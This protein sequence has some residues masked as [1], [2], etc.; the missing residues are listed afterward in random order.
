MYQGTNIVAGCN[1]GG[2]YV[3][4]DIGTTWTPPVSGLTNTHVTSLALSGSTLLAG[5]AGG[6]FLS[7]DGGSTWK[8][9]NTGLNFNMI[10]AAATVGADFLAAT[11][12]GV[13][14]STDGG[15]NWVESDNGMSIKNVSTFAVNGTNV[16]A[17]GSSGTVYLSTDSGV[18]WRNCSAGVQLGPVMSLLA[19]EWYLFA[20]V[21]DGGVWRRSMSE[22]L[23][24]DQNPALRPMETSLGQNFPNPFNP[25]TEIQYT[26]HDRQSTSIKVFDILGREVA[27]LLDEVKEPGRYSVTWNASGV[28][29]GVYYCRMTT[30]GSSKS[31]K[32]V[33][34]R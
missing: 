10:F 23:S 6:A 26:I 33:L 28:A 32:M 14:R 7:T 12:Y 8:V 16:F 4:P 11:S 15:A 3:S 2:V 18:N 29:S 25:T 20:G 9:S 30:G 1:G 5:T 27:L 19:T 31:I 17:S 13:F 22:V 21:Y 24:V 34:L